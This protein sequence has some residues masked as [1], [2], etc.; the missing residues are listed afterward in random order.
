MKNSVKL[1]SQIIT[2]VTACIT[3]CAGKVM[4]LSLSQGIR[5]VKTPEMVDAIVQNEADIYALVNTIANAVLFVIG[6]MSVGILMWGGVRYA[7]SGGDS[8]KVTEAK[9]TILY[10]LIGLLI[11]IFSYAIAVFVIGYATSKFSA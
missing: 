4:A 8:K 7:L 6:V 3:L 2:G 1:L 10:A 11:V 5:S 9:N